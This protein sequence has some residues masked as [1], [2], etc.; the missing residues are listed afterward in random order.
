MTSFGIRNDGFFNNLS[1]VDL[2]S[3]RNFYLPQTSLIPSP[4]Q[5]GQMTFEA[6][7]DFPFYSD[8]SLVWRPFGAGIPGG[9]I[10][11]RPGYT[12]TC[13]YIFPTW[14]GAY[15]ALLQIQSFRYLILDNTDGALVIPPGNWDMTNVEWYATVSHLSPMGVTIPVTIQDGATLNGLCG[16]F[17]PLGITYQG[18]STA[19]ITVDQ[20][21][22]PIYT[23]FSLYYGPT[24]TCSGTQ[25]FINVTTG[26]FLVALDIGSRLNG[27]AV[28]PIVSQIG[29]VVVVVAL[30]TAT[31][32][33]DNTINGL[34]TAVIVIWC[35]SVNISIPLVQM[36]NKLLVQLSNPFVY[37]TQP[38]LPT[39]NDDTNASYRPGDVW[40]C[41]AGFLIMG[42]RSFTNTSNAAGAAI[43]RPTFIVYTTAGVPGVNNDVTQG[44]VPGDMWIDS[45]TD[46]I[47]FNTNNSTGAAVW[48]SGV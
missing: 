23:A 35:S 1:A 41:N 13:P 7:S 31:F 46:Q 43:W 36:G 44:F 10:T 12:G 30:G 14:Q 48:R 27:G 9:T 39:V 16:I 6:S 21:G 33:D 2:H 38:A 42:P 8:T 28:P 11:F 40:I 17:G 18:T 34:G 3:F 25:P 26:E 45:G 15:D 24:I 19:C 22:N 29:A 5:P 4:T 47:Y 32:I 20:V 37:K